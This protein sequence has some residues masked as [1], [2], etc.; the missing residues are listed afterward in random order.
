MTPSCRAK[1]MSVAVCAVRSLDRCWKQFVTWRHCNTVPTVTFRDLVRAVSSGA[2]YAAECRVFNHFLSNRVCTLLRQYILEIMALCVLEDRLQRIHSMT[3]AACDTS[4]S[5]ASSS[6]V[7]LVSLRARLVLE[8]Q[9]MRVWDTAEHPYWL[10][11]EVQEGLQIRPKQYYVAQAMH[12]SNG[13]ICQLNMGEGKTR[14]IVPMLM[15]QQMQ[16][17]HICRVVLLPQLVDQ[18]YEYLHRTLCAGVF[19]QHLVRMPFHRGVPVEA[20]F[21]KRLLRTVSSMR[22][23]TTAL[24]CTPSDMASLWLKS[25]ELVTADPSTAKALRELLCT[26]PYYTIYDESD[27]VLHHKYQLIY[28]SGECVTLPNAEV[29]CHVVQGLLRALHAIVT[30]KSTALHQKMMTHAVVESHSMAGEFFPIR[31]VQSDAFAADIVPNLVVQMCEHLCTDPPREL[32]WMSQEIPDPSTAAGDVR[33]T[34]VIPYIVDA[35]QT[36]PEVGE[37]KHASYV[38][39]LRGML[40]FRK[41]ISALCQRYDVNFGIDATREKRVAVGRHTLD[42]NCLEDLSEIRFSQI[43]R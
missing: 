31:F 41:I 7:L 12:A 27:A 14:V 16:S 4:H 30:T 37:L 5:N 26:M 11:F 13:T 8:M 36:W 25:D 10:A 15:L 28:A 38:W 23:A 21:S 43:C 1:R 3:A 29:R 39:A 17:E 9:T 2:E 6:E 24:V 40:G 35:M 32:N 20:E 33:R 42:S 34:K 22:H 19:Q 18:T